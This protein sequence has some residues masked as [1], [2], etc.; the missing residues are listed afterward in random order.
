MQIQP[1]LAAEHVKKYAL[2][3]TSN[4]KITILYGVQNVCTV[5]PAFQPVRST[6]LIMEK[7]QKDETVT[8]WIINLK[9]PKGAGA[10]TT[11]LTPAPF[12]TSLF[13]IIFILLLR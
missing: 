8:I 7:K 6:L 10:K 4:F 2:S 3:L 9:P 11:V 12:I 13:Y 5:W 1:V